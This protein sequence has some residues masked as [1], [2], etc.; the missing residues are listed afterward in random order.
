ML[1]KNTSNST[2]VFEI[3]GA[4]GMPPKRYSVEPGNSVEIPDGYCR[5][6]QTTTNNRE[7]KPIIQQLCAAMAPMGEQ[8]RGRVDAAAGSAPGVDPAIAAI[9]ARLEAKLGDLASSNRALRTENAKLRKAVPDAGAAADEADEGDDE[10]EDGDD[11]AGAAELLAAPTD[12][13]A[14]TQVDTDALAKAAKAA[15][16]A[17]KAAKAAQG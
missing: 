3:D 6:Y 16:A 15:R 1:C 14:A 12:P 11:L 2:A 10:G 4:P 9:L 8:E 7:M 17:A 13:A 5:P